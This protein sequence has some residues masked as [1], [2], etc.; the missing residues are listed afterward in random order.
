[1][2]RTVERLKQKQVDNAKPS[3]GKFSK[4]LADG[5]GLYLQATRSKSQN[6]G[7]NRNWV[8]RYQLDGAR[9]EIGLGPPHTVGLAD[10]RDKARKFRQ[11]IVDGVN[12]IEAR[13]EE[14]AERQ[15]KAQ[16]LRAEQA[17]AQTF[18]QCA[19][20]YLAV[21]G[22]KWKNAK[23]AAQWLSTLETYAYPIIGDLNVADIDEAHLLRVLQPIWR[24][25]PETARR[26]RGRIEAILGYATVSKFR[27]GDN[28][29]RWRSHL[30][31]LLGGTQIA[32]EHHSAMPFADV[33]AFMVELRG[34]PK[35][36]SALALEFLI[37]TAGR[38]GEV[39][40]AKWSEIDLKHKTWTIPKERM[41]AKAEHR[42]PLTARAVEILKGLE[43]RGDFVFGTA[44][45]GRPLSNMALLE[46]LRGM[47]PGAGLTVHGFRSSFR[48]WAAERTAF[49]RDVVEMALAHT[50][51]D[52]VEAAY[53]RGDLFEKRRKLMEA[54]T[55]FLAKP[56]PVEAGNIISITRTRTRRD[57]SA[58]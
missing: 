1:M 55:G 34:K 38:T 22:D 9:Y 52:K 17:K 8:F 2:A 39:I 26:V 49:P 10:A 28:P 44:V 12:P 47:R 57:S 5:G 33:P 30:E 48:D 54:W 13:E 43:R 16:A 4:R 41:K 21:H 51:K 46:L 50:I 42:V 19:E 6:G 20:K 45:K 35:S 40:G 27:T 29:A 14:R 11:Q 25:I 24:Q 7:T 36:T 37:H 31:T 53:R 58:A 56:S 23:H 32:R 3:A 15:K 18:K